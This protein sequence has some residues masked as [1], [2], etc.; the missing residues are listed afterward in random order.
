[1]RVDQADPADE[2]D[3]VGMAGNAGPSDKPDATGND[4]EMEASSAGHPGSSPVLPDA[5]LRI[6]RTLTHRAKIE[7]VYRQYDLEQG[8]GTAK[9]P[10]AKRSPL[11]CAVLRPKSRI[12]IWQASG[13]GRPKRPGLPRLST[14]T[15]RPPGADRVYGATAARVE[16]QSS[17]A[18]AAASSMRPPLATRPPSMMTACTV[19][20]QS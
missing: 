3:D 11:R 8:N 15:P 20:C 12:A 14:A 10:N 16:I 4:L 13:A 7:A 18:T 5:A 19:L 2:P 17:P 1:M 9:S 6:E